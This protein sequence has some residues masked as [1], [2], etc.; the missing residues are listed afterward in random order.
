LCN[1]PAA[2]FGRIHPLSRPARS[3][4]LW[5]VNAQP[6]IFSGVTHTV[7]TYHNIMGMT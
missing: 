1:T 2:T 3:I 7:S 5:Q 4:H 6:L